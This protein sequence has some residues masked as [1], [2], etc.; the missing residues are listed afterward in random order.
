[1]N[2]DDNDDY[3]DNDNDN[4]NENNNNAMDT[5]ISMHQNID[6]TQQI[7]ENTQITNMEEED[8]DDFVEIW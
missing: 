1:M 5:Y 8:D 6:T 7:Q 2:D 4:Y 3:N